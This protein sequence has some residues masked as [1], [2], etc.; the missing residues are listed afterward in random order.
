MTSSSILVLNTGYK[1]LLSSWNTEKHL[2]KTKGKN[3]LTTLGQYETKILST[4]W[5][6]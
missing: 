1:K 5:Q 4:F 3:F 2:K 6:F